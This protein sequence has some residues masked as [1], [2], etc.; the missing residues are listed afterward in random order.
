MKRLTSLAVLTLVLANPFAALAQGGPPPD[1]RGPSPEMRAK[2]DKLR[3]DTR[4]A[5]FNAL[6]PD[7]Q[8]A[9]QAVIDQ[10]SSGKLK[11][12]R[13]AGAQINKILT[14]DETKA[15]LAIAQKTTDAMKAIGPPPGGPPG[16]DRRGPPPVNDA[17]HL[18]IFV[19]LS[20]EQ[21]RALMPPPGG[22]GPPR[23]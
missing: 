16:G 18:F 14:P 7:H 23:N 13:D 2:M 9:V 19:S 4:S 22:G 10:L 6:S 11:D 17:G 20:R 5:A 3:A 8:K 12:P 1:G 21:M 15:V